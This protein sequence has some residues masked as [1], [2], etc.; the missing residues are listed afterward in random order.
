MKYFLIILFFAFS[1]S[2]SQSS[3]HDISMINFGAEDTN[4]TNLRGY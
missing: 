1:N 2:F 4:T 3:V